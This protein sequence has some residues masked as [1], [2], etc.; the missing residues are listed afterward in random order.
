MDFINKLV[1]WV[2]PLVVLVILVIAFFGEE[3]MFEGLK[4]AAKDIQETIPV[5]IGAET[6]KPESPA[7]H[8]EHQTAIDQLKSAIE[9]MKGKDNCFMNYGQLPPLGAGGT[10]IVF[11]KGIDTYRMTI[12]GGE[13]GVIEIVSYDLGNIKPCVIA[14]KTPSDLDVAEMF[15][16]NFLKEP[17]ETGEMYYKPSDSLTIKYNGKNKVF[18][19]SGSN[20]LEDGGWLYTPDGKHICFFPTGDDGLDT[21]YLSPRGELNSIPNLVNS[22]KLSFCSESQKG[23]VKIHV[24]YLKATNSVDFIFNRGSEEWEYNAIHGWDSVKN[25]G[26]I[27]IAPYRKIAL[28]LSVMNEEEGYSYFRNYFLP[29][30]GRVKELSGVPGTVVSTPSKIKVKYNWYQSLTA[31]DYIYDR[32]AKKWQYNG[33]REWDYVENM[34]FPYSSKHKKIAEYLKGKDEQQGY[35]YFRS[36][37]NKEGMIRLEGVPPLK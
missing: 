37:I 24:D 22:E 1:F 33:I 27:Y 4:L 29:S 5:G 30:P 12:L 11:E 6:I 28:D 31:V 13:S 14:G 20:S 9:K 16:N 36:G 10:S 25:F 23:A 8:A 7:I 15:Y 18:H 32:N 34:G 17:A 35:E 3:S 26:S 2:I 21:S 19:D